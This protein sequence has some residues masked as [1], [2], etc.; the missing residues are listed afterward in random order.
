MAWLSILILICINIHQIQS[1]EYNITTATTNWQAVLQ[2]LKAG[3][4]AN[5]YPGTY[6]TSGSGYF[7]LTLN[8][9]L[10]KPIIIQSVPNQARPIIECASSGASAQNVMNI[11]GSNFM[12]KGIG[13]TKGSRGVRVGPA[14]TYIISQLFNL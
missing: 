11:Q 14:G 4:T 5:I 1:V 7:Q 10:T 9:L 13:F 6:K 12:I 8:G 3:D 2:G